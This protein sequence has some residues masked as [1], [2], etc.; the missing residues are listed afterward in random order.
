MELPVIIDKVVFR[1]E[2][3]FAILAAALNA[4][5]PKYLPELEDIVAKNT[6][7]TAYNNFIISVG[8]LDPH[9]HCEGGEYIFIGDFIKHEKYGEQFKSTFRYR[10]I[11]NTEEGMVAYLKDEMPNIGKVRSLEMVRKFSVAGILKIM[12]ENPNRLTEING[13]TEKRIPAIKE[14]W[15]KEADRRRLYLWLSDHGVPP[16]VGKKAYGVW[17]SESFKILTDNPYKLTEIDG[18]SF[19]KADALAHKILKVVPKKK[20]LVACMQFELEKNLRSNSNLCMPYKSFQEAILETLTQG[21]E[22]NNIKENMI[23]YTSLINECI[24]ENLDLFTAVK[25]I[26]ETS[27]GAYVYLRDI[28]EKEKYIAKSIYHRA[29]ETKHHRPSSERDVE[30]PKLSDEELE[31][32][33]K[34]IAKFNGK[35]IVLDET[36]K[37][38]IRSAFENKI[39]V[40]TG[41]GGTGKSTICRCIFHLAQEKKMPIR[42]M[43]PTGKAAQVLA[44]KTGY[45]AQTIHR[46][47]GM[48]P[49]QNYPKES[50]REDIVVIDE[51]SMVGIDTMH[52]IMCALEGNIWCNIVL[53]GDSNQLP[54]VSPGNFLTD[55]MQSG[56]ANVVRLDKI[57][58]QSEDSYISLLA[59]DVSMGKIVQIPENATDITWHELPN[60]LFDIMVRNVVKD[61]IKGES[62]DDLQIIAPMYKGIYG[63][64]KIN[65]VVQEL[66]SEVNGT[67]NRFLKRL[68]SQFHVG[69]RVI[70]IKNN[71]DKDIFNGDIGVVQ[72]AGRKALNPS[73]SDEQKDYVTVKFYGNDLIY[74]EEEIEQLKLAWCITVHKFQGSQ[75]SNI[76]F[77]MSDESHMMMSKEILYTAMTRAEKHLDIYGHMRMFK[78]APTKSAIR[79]RYTNMNNVIR[80]FR[81]N[82]QILKVL[83]KHEDKDGN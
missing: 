69:D 61:F 14:K 47:L 12:D 16:E 60:D 83:E 50:I 57:H 63:V 71:Y 48:M 75:S 44:S 1:N 25:N 30:E 39:S 28:W 13:L 40:I 35:E 8:D 55:I 17:G 67:K 27:N 24:K 46:S 3:G 59:N 6:K 36:Q 53:V 31:E 15:D 43:S 33:E 81:E 66:M 65:E 10:E 4:Y 49:D 34:D 72:E 37:L 51:V 58:R 41:G 74:V 21:N 18:Y 26:T 64:N 9:E 38:A 70:Q 11:P 54:S 52:A 62:I 79:K 77:I 42:M 73:V 78:L 20:R 32:A 82:R 29:I 68:F 22:Q 45:P 56:C 76:I 19:V 2:K 80:E 5:S 23:E 7:K